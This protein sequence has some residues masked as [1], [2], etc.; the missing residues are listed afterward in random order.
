MPCD[1]ARA[2]DNLSSG[3]EAGRHP[4][5]NS[6]QTQENPALDGASP[7]EV[8]RTQTFPNGTVVSVLR[9]GTRI[10]TT[11]EGVKLVQYPTGRTSQTNLDG[12]RIERLE[13]GTKL[14]VNPDGSTIS[15][16]P[17]GKRTQISK[18]GI[19]IVVHTDGSVVQTNLDGTE[20][21]LNADGSKV[22]SNPDKSMV[23]MQS[24]RG[25]I[26]I[27]ETPG[28]TSAGS[29]AQDAQVGGETVQ[30]LRIFKSGVRVQINETGPWQLLIVEPNGTIMQKGRD[31][32]L[33]LQDSERCAIYQNGVRSTRWLKDGTETIGVL[34]AEGE[35]ALRQ[36]LKRFE[37]L[38]EDK[39]QDYQQKLLLAE[40]ALVTSTQEYERQCHALKERLNAEMQRSERMNMKLEQW[41]EKKQTLHTVHDDAYIGEYRNGN[42]I[43]KCTKCREI[44]VIVVPVGQLLIR[45]RYR[46]KSTR[47]ASI[48]KVAALFKR[49]K[50]RAEKQFEC[51]LRLG[52]QWKLMDAQSQFF[53]PGQTKEM[54]EEAESVYKD[55]EL[56]RTVVEELQQRIV[57]LEAEKQEVED[58]LIDLRFSLNE[59][60]AQKASRLARMM[61]FLFG[62]KAGKGKK[63]NGALSRHESL[64]K[65]VENLKHREE[66]ASQA[67]TKLKRESQGLVDEKVTLRKQ[68]DNL[69]Q[70]RDEAVNRCAELQARIDEYLQTEDD[71][72]TRRSMEILP[73]IEEEVHMPISLTEVSPMI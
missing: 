49:I 45:V 70:E 13:D 21:R 72:S 17:D 15:L 48:T 39:A 44:A 9:D 67:L 47:I 35:A 61:P 56:A 12:T 30:H 62:R 46:C 25:S 14:Q 55:P 1:I 29:G 52:T 10:Q 69:S 18:S 71:A 64:L 32:I 4:Q 26:R 65:A 59:S 40:R 16:A 6:S 5:S 68:V 54:R 28:P 24:Q 23:R 60:K 19:R 53:G 50:S 66:R 22:Q 34:D 31:G 3:V 2:R 33:L 58:R 63:T 27:S 20:I 51:I 37:L 8:L 11:K 41:R 36:R 7:D 38:V 57:A 73:C 42:L 43:I